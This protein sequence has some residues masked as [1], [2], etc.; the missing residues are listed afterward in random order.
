MTARP[1]SD[2]LVVIATLHRQRE[3]SALVRQIRQEGV[4]CLVLVVDNGPM[5]G[6]HGWPDDVSV[7]VL[8]GCPA[9]SAAFVFGLRKALQ[10]AGKWVL[11]LDDDAAL[12]S[13]TLA[14]LMAVAADT[15][16]HAPEERLAFTCSTEGLG[17]GWGRLGAV[18]L[19]KRVPATS[20]GSHKSRL[21]PVQVAPWTGLLV[22]SEALRAL[23]S[24]RLESLLDYFFSWDDYALCAG[25]RAVDTKLY[26]I[27]D[28]SVRNFS[29]RT[30][31]GQ[32]WRE[33]Y[34]FRNV[35]LFRDDAQL[36]L[37]PV[38]LWAVAE[39]LASLVKEGNPL[40][41]LPVWKLR[42]Q[43]LRAGVRRSRRAGPLPTLQLAE[44]CR[45]CGDKIWSWWWVGFDQAPLGRLSYGRCHQCG[46]VQ[47]V[48]GS[49]GPPDEYYGPEY[50][51]FA[52]STR[53]PW[54]EALRELRDKSAVGQHTA[55]GRAL[56]FMFP[57]PILAT[58]RAH[59]TANARLLD[60]GCGAGELV[61]RLRRLGFE[62][63]KGVDPYLPDSCG[64]SGDEVF[65]KGDV[66]AVLERDGPGSYDVVV[67]NHVL[68]HIPNQHQMAETVA[69]VLAPKGVV[70]LRLPVA[71][72]ALFRYRDRW[73]QLDPPRH[74]VFHTLESL[75]KL[76]MDA[77]NFEVVRVLFDSNGYQFPP[78][79]GSRCL[80][81]RIGLDVWARWL[82]WRRRGDQVCFVL[83]SASASERSDNTRGT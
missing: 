46:L 31:L 28:L 83:T 19:L 67:L 21:Q 34:R 52:G 42:F 44:P 63:A 57:D 26:A 6:L 36:R 15:S 29:A 61:R 39:I 32:E 75:R 8:S 22:S 76:W 27:V 20:F 11:C 40:R 33:Y 2:L 74:I 64:A 82:N 30:A 69:H 78:G 79:P 60:I 23:Q 24:T 81:V 38:A 59:A 47:L 37:L 17:L 12:Q 58:V 50:H 14:S 16:A 51:A 65:L 53:S 1:E 43:G 49:G 35:W 68:E 73:P 70:V 3:V 5:A 4:N 18:R 77:G 41:R 56:C 72:G 80:V 10:F 7:E 55:L 45:V 66:S 54:R 71:I 62:A 25:L 13:G 9:G 48:G